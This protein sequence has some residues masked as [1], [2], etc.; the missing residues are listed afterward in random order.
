MRYEV[1]HHLEES[2][3]W[4]LHTLWSLSGFPPSTQLCEALGSPLGQ[5]PEDTPFPVG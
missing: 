1:V 4:S 5:R 3:G 2:Q